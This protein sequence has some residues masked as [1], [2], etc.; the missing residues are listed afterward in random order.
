MQIAFYRF[1]EATSLAL[2]PR[3]QKQ[4]MLRSGSELERRKPV[5]PTMYNADYYPTEQCIPCSC[6]NA[7]LM[8]PN[9]VALSMIRS[10]PTACNIMFHSVMP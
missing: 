1:I 9:T 7:E 6:N 4:M 8:I 5:W 10:C 3:I 2:L